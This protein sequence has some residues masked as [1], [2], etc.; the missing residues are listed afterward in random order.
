[1]KTPFT[2]LAALL[3]MTVPVGAA[4]APR[5]VRYGGP[6]QRDPFLYPEQKVVPEKE[7]A[8]EE[9]SNLTFALEGLIWESDRP[10]AIINGKI[11]EPGGNIEGA[12][13]LDIDEKGVK[14]RYKGQEF[15]LHPRGK[16]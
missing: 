7:A 12:E 3:L 14:M 8:K 9:I 10:Q 5:E 1:M 13:V 15:I 4:D 6:D 11:V 2:I 16:K